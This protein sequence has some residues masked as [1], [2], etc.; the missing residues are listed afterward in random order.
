M[1]DYYTTEYYSTPM[2]AENI[3]TVPLPHRPI[4]KD[5]RTLT[6]KEMRLRKSPMGGIVSELM[7]EG[8]VPCVAPIPPCSPLSVCAPHLHDVSSPPFAIL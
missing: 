6:V 1:A 8:T 2:E 3:Y 7:S 5:N 4:R